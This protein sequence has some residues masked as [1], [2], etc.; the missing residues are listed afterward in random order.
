MKK[1]KSKKITDVLTDEEY[2]SIIFQFE[3]CD[4]AIMFYDGAFY[5]C[6]VCNAIVNRAGIIEH[7]DPLVY[8]RN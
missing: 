1:K 7:Q 5:Q 8:K 2:A 4:E 3:S 6:P